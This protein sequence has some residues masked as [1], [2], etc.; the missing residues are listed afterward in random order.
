M[1]AP[2]SD[3]ARECVRELGIG[4]I[5]IEYL[6]EEHALNLVQAAIGQVTTKYAVALADCGA[7]IDQLNQVVDTLQRWKDEALTVESW[8]KI[9][10]DVVR[11]DPDIRLGDSVAATAIRFIGARAKLKKRCADLERA[12]RKYHEDASTGRTNAAQVGLLEAFDLAV[13]ALTDPVP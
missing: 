1:S 6:T 9:V 8:W 13:S 12:L 7:T 2:I 5:E 10:D 4:T 11:A 3:E